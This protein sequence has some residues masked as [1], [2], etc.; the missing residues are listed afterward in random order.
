ML[1]QDLEHSLILY[2]PKFPEK[3]ANL[4]TKSRKDKVVIIHSTDND[5]FISDSYI[6]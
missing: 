5:R 2:S 1:H 3:G 6:F 4:A